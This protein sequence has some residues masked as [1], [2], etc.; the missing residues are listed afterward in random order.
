[1]I[2]V[3]LKSQHLPLR[4]ALAPPKKEPGAGIRLLTL[5]GAVIYINNSPTNL[6]RNEQDY[7]ICTR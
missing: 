3:P 5:A 6:K 4:N 7:I 2:R 1:V